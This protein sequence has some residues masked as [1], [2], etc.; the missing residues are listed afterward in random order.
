M[1]YN[2]L[3]R[4]HS[5]SSLTKAEVIERI[6]GAYMSLEYTGDYKDDKDVVIAAVASNGWHLE[7]ASDRLKSDRE[8][9]LTAIANQPEAFEF[10]STSLSTDRSFLIDAAYTNGFILRLTSNAIKS[11]RDVVLAAVT[12]RGEAFHYASEA[13]KED[14]EVALAAVISCG[15][16]IRF[17]ANQ[18]QGDRELGVAAMAAT[19]CI[20]Q[21]FDR[22][23]HS[24]YGLKTIFLPN[25]ITHIGNL[26]FGNCIDLKSVTLPSSLISMRETAFYGCPHLS[27]IE[28]SPTIRAINVIHESD[29]YERDKNINKNLGSIYDVIQKVGFLSRIPSELFNVLIYSTIYCDHDDEP[30]N[31]RSKTS[32]GFVNWAVCGKIKDSRGRLPLA[33]AAESGLKWSEGLHDLYNSNKPAIEKTDVVTG[34]QP[35]MLAA[36]GLKSD[37]ETVFMLLQEHPAAIYYSNTI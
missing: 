6:T 33:F 29:D 1:S 11:D 18:L 12:S 30:I 13:L 35:F 36:I 19:G 20:T 31:N 14:R 15:K 8:V 34:L 5:C 7:D 25:S 32:V 22:T 23:F 9:V 21:I 28:I 3:S 4:H 37:L 16:A 27:S 17:V 26:A 10:A 2:N 24:C